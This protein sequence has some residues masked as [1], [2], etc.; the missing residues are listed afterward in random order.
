MIAQGEESGGDA[1]HERR[2]V[3]VIGLLMITGL[4]FLILGICLFVCWV[5]LH[6]FNREGDARQRQP[7][8]P[9]AEQVAEFPQPRLL[10]H[11]GSEREKIQKAEQTTL[12]SY[13]WV[14]RASGVARIP[15]T[16]AMQ[17]IVERGLP[18]VGAGQTRLQLMQS[19]PRTNLQPN[20]PISAPIPEA[21]P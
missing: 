17:L 8:A 4:L 16:R 14:D 1:T 19:R 18:E 13:G 9:R 3:D 21:T 2:D 5:F 6:A 15:I 12:E 10:V 11:P 7:R 20:E